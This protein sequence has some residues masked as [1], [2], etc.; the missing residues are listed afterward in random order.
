M[1][2]MRRFSFVPAALLASA[3]NAGFAHAQG[4]EITLAILPL[5]VAPNAA[6]LQRGMS[7]VAQ[8]IVE[9]VG[10]TGL[11][12]TIDRSADGAIEQELKKAESYRNFDSRVP[13]G[14]TGQL[15]STVMLLGVVEHAT[16]KPNGK[17]GKEQR[18]SAQFGIRLKIVKTSS[19][20]L[21][22]STLLTVGNNAGAGDAIEKK[23]G[24]ALDILPGFVKDK[25]KDKIDKSVESGVQR[26]T[27]LD[28]GDATAEDAIRTAARKLKEPLDEFLMDSYGAVM[29]ASK[30][31]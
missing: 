9:I 17:H 14:T 1:E 23:A 20:E 13:V 18:F 5:G 30:K 27:G 29:A 31:K 28:V 10:G 8:E 25:V 26:N 24:G 11:Y 21:I 3:L 19:G 15:N 2:Q 22:R 4:K 12:T 6:E 7:S 16:V